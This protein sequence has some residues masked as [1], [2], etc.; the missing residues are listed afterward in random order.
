MSL[1]ELACVSGVSLDVDVDVDVSGEVE[2]ETFLGG[3]AIALL[4]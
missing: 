1:W 4:R 3:F 2:P